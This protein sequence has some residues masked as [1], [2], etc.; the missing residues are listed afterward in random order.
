[1]HNQCNAC[2]I[3]TACNCTRKPT[4][5]GILQFYYC[6]LQF[7][8]RCFVPR[9]KKWNSVVSFATWDRLTC[10]QTRWSLMYSNNKVSRSLAMPPHIP[11]LGQKKM[12]RQGR[13]YFWSPQ[14]KDS[15]HLN[16]T[17]FEVALIGRQKLMKRV[18]ISSARFL[19]NRR[20]L[21]CFVHILQPEGWIS[22]PFTG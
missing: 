1:M 12:A 2:G 16:P 11:F 10:S 15:F 19:Q 8:W 6:L 21:F 18:G 17:P 5:L 9:T 4:L 7:I 13:Q 3:I 14:N 22:L 20:L